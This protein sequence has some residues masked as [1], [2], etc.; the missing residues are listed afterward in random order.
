MLYKVL[1]TFESVGESSSAVLHTGAAQ[2]AL[3]FGFQYLILG[4]LGSKGV[5]FPNDNLLDKRW[6][7][8]VHTRA[9]RSLWSPSLS[10]GGRLLSLIAGRRSSNMADEY[11]TR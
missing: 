1:V 11:C 8:S 5:N 3:L 6:C 9:K 4:A 10:L 7:I 2:T